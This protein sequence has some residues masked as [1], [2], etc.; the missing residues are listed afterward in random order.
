MNVDKRP[1][2]LQANVKPRVEMT[3]AEKIS[4][5]AFYALMLSI[6]VVSFAINIQYIREAQW[7]TFVILAV[8]AIY[9]IGA[10]LVII[11]RYRNG[12]L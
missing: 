3:S 11:A 7:Y 2:W 4:R 6:I 5:C 1:L 10:C 9:F 8:T 12:F